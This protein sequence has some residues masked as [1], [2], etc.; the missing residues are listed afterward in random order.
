MTL[1][2]TES[3]SLYILDRQNMRWERVRAGEGSTFVR[4]SGGDLLEFPSIAL[5]LPLM[6][7]G[8]S[9]TPGGIMRLIFTTPV[10]EVT[11][12]QAA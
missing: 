3:G 7:F 2:R 10:V 9:L 1:V 11:E 6:M 8:L 4:T 12:L 5:G